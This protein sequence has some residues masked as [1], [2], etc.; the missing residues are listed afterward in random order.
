MKRII[1]ILGAVLLLSASTSMA[2]TYSINY[3]HKTPVLPGGTST[4][5]G[6]TSPYA[7]ATIET[8]DPNASFTQ[9]WSWNGSYTLVSDGGNLPNRFSAPSYVDPFTGKTKEST[10]YISVPDGI[11]NNP[12]SIGSVTVTNLGGEYNYLGLWWGSIDTYNKIE[13]LDNGAVIA[14][15]TGTDVTNPNPANGGQIDIRTNKYVNIFLQD[16]FDSFR[17][18]STNFAFEVDNIAINNVPEPGTIVLLGAGLLGLG[19][20]GRRRVQK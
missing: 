18:T 8:F 3:L 7:G 4:D 12:S 13:F 2:T 16:E 5:G 15:V 10:D 9:A 14:T 6:Y 1:S 20:Y 19:L 17:F 11:G